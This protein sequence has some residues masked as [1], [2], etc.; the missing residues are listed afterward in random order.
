MID[1]QNVTR[2]ASS[3]LSRESA[4]SVD[5]IRELDKLEELVEDAPQ[6][7]GRA[8][9]I[10]ADR[11]FVCTNRIRAFL[12]EEIKHASRISR[13]SER[14]IQEAQDEV[15]MTLESAREEATRLLDDARSRAEQLVAS[16]EIRQQ[17]EQHA[18]RIV[19]E[20]DA[21]A[22]EIRTGADKYARE[23]LAGLDQ[24]LGR[25]LGTVQRGQAKLEQR[26][27]NSSSR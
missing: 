26:E 17:A 25:I 16:H 13:D 4:N 5:I 11:F 18:S 19:A 27:G 15:H 7:G 10:N 22:K 12:P 23:V 6:V 3:A 1:Q 24:F 8:L 20:A 2:Q 14:L 21:R 9:W